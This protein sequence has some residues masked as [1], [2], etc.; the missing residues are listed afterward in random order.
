MQRGRRERLRLE[1]KYSLD[2]RRINSREPLEELL[3]GGSVSE[4]REQGGYRH[5]TASEHPGT[6]DFV[7]VLLNR[8]T[9]LPV[10]DEFPFAQE[11]IAAVFPLGSVHTAYVARCR[12]STQS[13]V[14]RAHRSEVRTFAGAAA[15]WL[16]VL[17]TD[18]GADNAKHVGR[19]LEYRLKVM[20]VWRV[21]LA[22]RQRRLLAGCRQRL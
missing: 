16:E 13:G 18:W 19:L 22:E 17:A 5:T 6:A 4:I 10:H 2:T 11:T 15:F 20:E 21:Y 1:V 3:H 7:G 9:S 14:A 12:S 8:S